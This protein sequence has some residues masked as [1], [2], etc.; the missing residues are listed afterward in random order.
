MPYALDSVDRQIIR[1]LQ[2]DGRT[3]NVEIA[4]R[5]GVSE[6]TVRKRL[7][8]LLSSR[9][10]RITAMPD[11]VRFGF[12]TIT[13]ITIN[14]DFARV[15]QI[16]EQIAQVP[17]VRAIYLTAGESNLIVEAWFASNDDLLRFMTQHIGS[18]PG[19][20]RT[21]TSHVLRTIKDSSEW[22]LPTSS[23]IIDASGAR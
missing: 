19:I 5:I 12:S 16:T 21:T 2:Q 10:I 9:V 23:P 14:V 8:R 20:R 13:F 6:P 17:E 3:S 1:I 18:I 4:R 11:P 15:G 7:E 22:I